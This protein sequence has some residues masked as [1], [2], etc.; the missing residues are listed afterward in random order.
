MSDSEST[1]S[2]VNSAHG[3]YGIATQTCCHESHY[4]CNLLPV[5]VRAIR[6]LYKELCHPSE[7]QNIQKDGIVLVDRSLN[8]ASDQLYG[9]VVHSSEKTLQIYVNGEFPICKHKISV[10]KLRKTTFTDFWRD[11]LNQ[12]YIHS[13]YSIP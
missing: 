8:F 1:N 9:L 7:E 6:F 5:C 10:V 4:I 2:D 13:I 12:N 11:E 3:Y